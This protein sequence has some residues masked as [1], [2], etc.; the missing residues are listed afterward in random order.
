MI[1]VLKNLV[2]KE[3]MYLTLIFGDIKFTNDISI[4]ANFDMEEGVRLVSQFNKMNKAFEIKDKVF[5]L[6]NDLITY[7]PNSAYYI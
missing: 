1:I 6:V 5:E 7:E 3:E 2:N 4:A